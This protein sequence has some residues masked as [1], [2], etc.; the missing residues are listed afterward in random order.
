MQVK[1]FLS[2]L[3]WTVD[4]MQFL[5]EN[6]LNGCQI[7]GLFGSFKTE[8][9]QFSVWNIPNTETNHLEKF[10]WSPKSYLSDVLIK[11]TA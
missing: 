8:S 10:C 5:S 7:F 6:Y 9:K 4:C 1:L 11:D 3:I 2:L